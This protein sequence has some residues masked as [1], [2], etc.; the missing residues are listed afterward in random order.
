MVSDQLKHT[1]RITKEKLKLT[2]FHY[3]SNLRTFLNEVIYF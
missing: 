2:V 3:S 1:T